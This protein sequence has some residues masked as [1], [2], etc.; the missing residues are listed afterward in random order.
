MIE[1]EKDVFDA[2]AQICRGDFQAPA[3]VWTTNFV[4]VGESRS[5][6][7]APLRLS[8]RTSTSVDVPDKPSTTIVC[9]ASPPLRL[10]ER[11]SL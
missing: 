8:I 4:F 5:V 3:A 2:E 11:R 6:C 7:V 10:I 1:S 9:P